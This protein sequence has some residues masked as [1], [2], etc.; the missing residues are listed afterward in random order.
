MRDITVYRCQ[1]AFVALALP[2]KAEHRKCLEIIIIM[3]K[4]AARFSQTCSLVQL[5][6]KS[7]AIV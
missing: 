7:L 3:K 5:F 2:V 1:K 4:E 6:L